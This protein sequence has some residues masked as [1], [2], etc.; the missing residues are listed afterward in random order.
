MMFAAAEMKVNKPVNIWSGR[1]KKKKK[2]Q[3]GIHQNAICVSPSRQMSSLASVTHISPATA[4]GN[5]LSSPLLPSL[6]LS[7]LLILAYTSYW[8]AHHVWHVWVCELKKK[9][10]KK[11]NFLFTLQVAFLLTRCHR[12]N[13]MWEP[14]ASLMRCESKHS[15]QH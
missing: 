12:D 11:S 13:A 3:S 5:D 8:A 10:E 9:K 2:Q 15:S 4:G 14:R 1:E 7:S 6:S